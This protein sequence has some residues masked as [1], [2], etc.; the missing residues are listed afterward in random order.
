VHRLT[1]EDVLV[2]APY[3]AQVARLKK[4]LSP[5]SIEVGTVDRFQ[6]REAPV[7][8]YS[9]AASSPEDAPRGMDFL[10]SL[11]RLNVATSRARCTCVL[12]ASP[13]LFQPDC[14]TPEQIRLAKA[15]CRYIELAQPLSC[16]RGWPWRGY[17][18]ARARFRGRRPV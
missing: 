2:V 7:V 3:N 4:R 18:V 11:H 9:M 10:Y 13:R 14:R 16:N 15:F 12:V 1:P 8:I 5:L 17:P 6:G